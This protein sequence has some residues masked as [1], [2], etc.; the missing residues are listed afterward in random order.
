MEG[1][2]MDELLAYL[3]GKSRGGGESGGGA[4]GTIYRGFASDEIC[5]GT[6]TNVGCK[7]WPGNLMHLVMVLQLFFLNVQKPLQTNLVRVLII[8]TQ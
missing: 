6:Y 8:R 4:S 2:V 5:F 7:L 3:L 1:I